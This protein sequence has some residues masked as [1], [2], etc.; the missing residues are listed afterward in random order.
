MSFLYIIFVC[1][2]GIRGGYL[3]GKN[4]KKVSA[5][6]ITWIIISIVF[7]SFFLLKLIPDLFLWVDDTPLWVFLVLFILFVI[8]PV[9]RYLKQ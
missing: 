7:F 2:W 1:L 3:F 5:R 4:E 6:D 9:Y 8:K